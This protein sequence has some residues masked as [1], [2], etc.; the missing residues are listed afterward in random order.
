ME[1]FDKKDVSIQ[2]QIISDIPMHRVLLSFND[3]CQGEAFVDW[4]SR[5]GIDLFKKWADENGE[6]Y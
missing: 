6:N 2:E 1:T 5:E 4:W 3:D